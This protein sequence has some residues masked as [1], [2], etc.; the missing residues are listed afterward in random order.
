MPPLCPIPMGHFQRQAHRRNIKTSSQQITDCSCGKGYYNA[1]TG[2]GTG[3]YAFDYLFRSGRLCTY[4]SYPFADKKENC[5]DEDCDL[6]KGVRMRLLLAGTP[7]SVQ[8]YAHDDLFK[9][10]GKTEK[11]KKCNKKISVESKQ[12]I[13]ILPYE[14]RCKDAKDM[15]NHMLLLAGWKILDVN[16]KK[17]LCWKFLN[18]WGKSKGYNG[19]IYLRDDTN[20][21][22]Q[23][24]YSER[25]ELEKSR[26]W[27]YNPICN[28]WTF[29]PVYNFT[30][31]LDTSNQRPAY[32]PSDMGLK[33]GVAPF[34]SNITCSSMNDYA[35]GPGFFYFSG[36]DEEMH[37]VYLEADARHFIDKTVGF[38]ISSPIYKHG[39]SF[40]TEFYQYLFVLVE[41]DQSSGFQA[42]FCKLSI[43]DCGEWQRTHELPF[44]TYDEWNKCFGEDVNTFGK[45]TNFYN[46]NEGPHFHHN[47]LFIFPTYTSNNIDYVTFEQAL[48]LDQNT[49]KLYVKE[50]NAAIYDQLHQPQLP[51]DRAHFSTVIVER[52]ECDVNPVCICKNVE[53]VR[54]ADVW[55]LD[56]LTWTWTKWSEHGI[57]VPLS[58]TAY[59]YRAPYIYVFGGVNKDSEDTN[60][61]ILLLIEPPT[62]KN[63]AMRAAVKTMKPLLGKE[64]RFDEDCLYTDI[65]NAFV[66]TILHFTLFC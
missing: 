50:L 6:V 27:R 51:V 52:G 65:P 12:K 24:N 48:V 18:T 16:G 57:G 58:N 25:E 49:Q 19:Y 34:S 64:E 37:I 30:T 29:L 32:F 43:S 44:Y 35:E 46:Q 9:Y 15:P 66:E 8:I 38:N 36:S 45:G 20:K 53:Y 17:V 2:G 3:A 40:P 47:Q 21:C 41:N 1:G 39:C 33:K 5:R 60:D 23:S 11:A 42:Q 61:L 14:G 56:L 63:L 22:R 4:K 13:E 7:I 26:I 54:Y 28:E 10:G 62:L 59:I 55:T 31:C